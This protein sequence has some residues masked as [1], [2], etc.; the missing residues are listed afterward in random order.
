MKKWDDL[1]A[2]LAVA[3]AAG[4]TGAAEALGSSP[5]T[6]GRHVDRLEQSLG[7][8]LFVRA[9]KGYTLTQAGQS[10]IQ[11]AEAMEDAALSVERWQ[12]GLAGQSDVRVSA[13]S[14]ISYFLA[15]HIGRLQHADDPFGLTF[16][17]S[18][19]RLDIARREADIGIRN[20][21]PVEPGLAGK[22]L[23]EIAFAVFR[24]KTKTAE[25]KG[26]GKSKAE[27]WIQSAAN[28][29]SARW[30]SSHHGNQIAVEANNPRMVMD[31]CEAGAGFAVLPCFVGDGNRVLER[32]S[33]PI[34][35]LTHRQ[36]LV[37][38]HETRHQRAVRTVIGR[39][40]ALMQA[41]REL[42]AWGDIRQ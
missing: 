3:R 24:R 1:Q 39:L 12:A 10:L 11:H 13:G 18:E 7:Q 8:R 20:A 36:W 17:S 37:L 38:H 22:A 21:R 29:P 41:N 34:E 35:A 9:A 25:G 14:W 33:G 27:G 42:F 28:T 16:V 4:L 2:F 31:L 5:A 30:V 6:L 15:G 23:G 32:V 40:E 26:L 19:A